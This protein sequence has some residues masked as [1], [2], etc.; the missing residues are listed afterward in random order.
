MRIV[1]AGALALALAGCAG[2]DAPQQQAAAQK[3]GV[4][5][6]QAATYAPQLGVQL[7]AFYKTPNGV[8]YQDTK[9][10]TGM[11]AAPGAQV[12]TKYE[13]WLPDGTRFDGGQIDF[14]LAQGDVI[15]GWDEGI[16]GMRVGG[17]RKLVI[18]AALGYGAEGMPPDIPPN[19]TL[20][21]QVELTDVK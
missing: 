1:L 6:P 18:P 2:G 5:D 21:F 7:A 10:G 9:T 13:G 3:V 15:R 14:R 19:A 12:S 4:P 17:V 11:A 16:Q 8:Y 20:V